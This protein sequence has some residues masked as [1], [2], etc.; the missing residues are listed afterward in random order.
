MHKGKRNQTLEEK[1]RSCKAAEKENAWGVLKGKVKKEMLEK[2]LGGGEG[3]KRKDLKVRKLKR[4]CLK[5]NLKR[6]ELWG[7]GSENERLKEEKLEGE[8]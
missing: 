8:S 5:G 2:R 7:R 1:R 6:E 3:L 4:K